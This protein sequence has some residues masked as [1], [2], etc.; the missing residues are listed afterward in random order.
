VEVER[1]ETPPPDGKIRGKGNK[2]VV[3]QY[4]FLALERLQEGSKIRVTEKGIPFNSVYRAR[5]FKAERALGGGLAVEFNGVI[6]ELDKNTHELK[7][8]GEYS[9]H[10]GLK[11]A[12][13]E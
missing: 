6:Y 12:L 11:G 10:E 1:D 2:M 8:C 7:P 13:W 4:E 9:P 3:R 5:T